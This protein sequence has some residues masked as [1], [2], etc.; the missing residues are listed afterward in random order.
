[1]FFRKFAYC[2]VWLKTGAD[3]NGL[4]PGK[5]GLMIFTAIIPVNAERRGDLLRGQKAAQP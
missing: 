1:V 3:L 5:P 2:G 4:P